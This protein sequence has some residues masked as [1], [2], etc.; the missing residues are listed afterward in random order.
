MQETPP[1][2]P[3]L[4]CLP[5]PASY[6]RF[7]MKHLTA[8]VSIVALAATAA[9][10]AAARPS[11]DSAT[12][13]EHI[14]VLASDRFAGRA[15][16]GPG[17]DL[18]V[19]YLEDQFRRLGLKPGN[20]DGTY[21]QTV[22]LVSITAAPDAHLTLQRGGDTRVLK[23]KDEVVPWTKRV[24]E[25]GKSSAQAY[26]MRGRSLYQLSSGDPGSGR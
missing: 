8:L 9:G 5:S 10:H 4:S 19:T 23:F 21:T 3:P 13:L 22:P 18:T 17:E 12:F 20:T 7:A 11:I 15:P 24:T 16:G 1:L 14:K 25:R 26:A 6:N 2:P